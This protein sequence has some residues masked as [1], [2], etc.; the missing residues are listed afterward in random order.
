MNLT[1]HHPKVWP[2][3]LQITAFTAAM[4]ATVVVPF[5]T[6][7]AVYR[8]RG[9]RGAVP[10]L[11]FLFGALLWSLTQTMEVVNTALA[12]KTVWCS[13]VFLGA[14]IAPAA[15]L[16]VTAA[17]TGRDRWLTRRSVGAIAAIEACING[18]VWTNPV[19]GL[20]LGEPSLATAGSLTALEPAFGPLFYFHAGFQYLFVSL[21]LY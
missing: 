11:A 21:G 13:A 4:A 17:V 16:L 3:A 2:M 19:H 6:F 14:T 7:L 18:L 10:L 15:Y 20:M 5:V 9:R 1:D 8:H 12:A